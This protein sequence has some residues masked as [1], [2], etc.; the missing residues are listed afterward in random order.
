MLRIIELLNVRKPL[1]RT[2]YGLAQLA[3]I[4]LLGAFLRPMDSVMLQGRSLASITLVLI[5]MVATLSLVSLWTAK[6]LLDVGWSQTWALMLIG[7]FLMYALLA[8]GRSNPGLLRAAFIPV[9]LLFI[10]GCGLIAALFVKP[11]RETSQKLS[12]Q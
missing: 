9:G 8:V 2:E 4:I 3:S 11:G 6:R 5:G 7:P 12:I 10:I 1:G